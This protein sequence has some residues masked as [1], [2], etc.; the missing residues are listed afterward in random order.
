MWVDGGGLFRCGVLGLGALSCFV[1]PYNKD[2]VFWLHVPA[3]PFKIVLR[4][5]ATDSKHVAQRRQYPLTWG[6]ENLPF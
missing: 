3:R 4:R 1:G 2:P 5:I 6:S